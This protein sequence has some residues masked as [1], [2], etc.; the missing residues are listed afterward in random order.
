MGMFDSI[1]VK[2]P[3]CKNELEFQSKSGACMLSYFEEKK[4]PL[5]VAIGSNEDIVKCKKCKKNIQILFKLPSMEVG[6]KLKITKEE[7][8]YFG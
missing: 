8:D 1:L 3:H 7:E 5:I 4:I 2:C 6:Y